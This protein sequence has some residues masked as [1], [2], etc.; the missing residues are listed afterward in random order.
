ME[1]CPARNSPSKCSRPT[2]VVSH[3]APPITAMASRIPRSTPRMPVKRGA[4]AGGNES[5]EAI[6]KSLSP[7]LDSLVPR[8][9]DPFK[10]TLDAAR[11]ARDADAAS[12][13]D[14]L[15]READ[16]VFLRNDIHQV[17]LDFFGVFV[18]GKV[19]AIGNADDV[20]IDHYA[21]RNAERGTEH[22][23][24]G[25]AGDSRQS[26]NFI[27]RFGDLAG[28]FFDDFLAGAHYGFRFVAEETGRSDVLLELRGIRVSEGG[29]LGIFA[30]QSF[31]DLIDAHVSALRG[32]DG[33]NQ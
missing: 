20:G 7:K 23:V 15:V 14:D 1:V 25:F 19:E 22:D 32:K 10:I 29:R 8:I 6:S 17:V 11:L 26:E 27:H 16:P 5:R 24:A 4:R 9:T 31:G 33:G 30:I 28:E 2:P 13:P 21:G 18:F 12:V 3:T